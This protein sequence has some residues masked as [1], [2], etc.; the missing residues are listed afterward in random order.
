MIKPR[1]GFLIA[2]FL[3]CV[4]LSA[5]AQVTSQQNGVRSGYGS[6]SSSGA[7]SKRSANNP[8]GSA[9]QNS[10]SNSQGRS[11]GALGM[12]PQLQKELGIKQ[13]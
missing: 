11:E 1:P 3:A 6:T 7:T 13:Q 4:P 12:T 10:P 5:F 2:V 8:S 9:S